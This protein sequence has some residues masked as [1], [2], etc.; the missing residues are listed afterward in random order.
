MLQLHL[1]I[2]CFN[3]ATRMKNKPQETILVIVLGLLMLHLFLIKSII[4]IYVAIVLLVISIFSNYALLLIHKTWYKLAEILGKINGTILLS[5]IFYLL[6]TPIAFL[7]K[8]FAAK[9]NSFLLEKNSTTSFNNRNHL[10]KKE[11]FEKMW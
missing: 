11:D 4:I 2:L 1:Y 5:I 7:S 8:I 9:N 10:H 6:L 3:A